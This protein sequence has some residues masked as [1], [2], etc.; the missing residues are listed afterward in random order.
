MLLSMI[1][2][3]PKV[4]YKGRSRSQYTVMTKGQKLI[5]VTL[6]IEEDE[7]E[8]EAKSTENLFP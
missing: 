2:N 1:K 3:Y 6:G 5:F 8:S 4:T 7:P